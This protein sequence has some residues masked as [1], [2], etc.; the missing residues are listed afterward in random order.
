MKKFKQLKGA[1]VLTKEAQ[2]KVN[3]GTVNYCAYP[4]YRCEDGSCY[5]WCSDPYED[6]FL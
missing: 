5:E 1:K 4:M 6:I 3:G 2:K